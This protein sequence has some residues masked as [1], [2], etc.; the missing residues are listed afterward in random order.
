M[1]EIVEVCSSVIN[2]KVTDS[3]P[4]KCLQISDYFTDYSMLCCAS[5]FLLTFFISV[6]CVSLFFTFFKLLKSVI[7]SC[8]YRCYTQQATSNYFQHNCVQYYKLFKFFVKENP[9]SHLSVLR[10]LITTQVRG[11]STICGLVLKGLCSAVRYFSRLPQGLSLTVH[12]YKQHS[13]YTKHKCYWLRH[14][15]PEK[16]RI[17]SGFGSTVT[18][19]RTQ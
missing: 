16:K 18:A 8:F 11:H 13:H 5:H 3:Q 17:M 4:V 7:L 12:V 14:A 2:K 19:A 6:F 10:L 9:H 15:F 1:F